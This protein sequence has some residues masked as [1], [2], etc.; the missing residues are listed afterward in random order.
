MKKQIPSISQVV[1][2]IAVFGAVFVSEVIAG[3]LTADALLRNL[4]SL[5]IPLVFYAVYRL[6]TRN[7]TLRFSS[8]KIPRLTIWLCPLLF[9]L[10]NVI[11][12]PLSGWPTLGVWTYAVTTCLF[13]GLMEEMMFRGVLFHVF[14]NS[15]F[16][17]YLL[18][19]S[20]GFG[21]LHFQQGIRGIVITAIV[22]LSYGL[23]RIAGAPLTI[24]ILCHAATN[25][26]QRLPHERLECYPVIAQIALCYTVF[27]SMN[28]LMTPKHWS[29]KAME[30]TS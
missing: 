22:G 28:Y 23:A 29:N 4:I 6:K 20:F 19:S 21:L 7:H 8:L 1:L 15:R 25:L 3:V 18:V 17:I 13:I 10:T 9:V 11:G 24:L 26:P 14:N 30:A 5:I 27:I 2:T 16:P 12:K